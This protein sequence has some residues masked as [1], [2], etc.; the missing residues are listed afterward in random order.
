MCYQQC[1]DTHFVV[2]EKP[3][4]ACPKLVELTMETKSNYPI[5]TYLKGNTVWK[6]PVPPGLKNFDPVQP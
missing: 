5:S 6:N 4:F 1:H 3:L 2:L